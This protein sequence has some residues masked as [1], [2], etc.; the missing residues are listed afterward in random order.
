MRNIKDIQA[1]IFDMDG[2]I[3]DS[4]HLQVEAEKIVCENHHI[5][6]PDAEWSNFKGK[7][8]IDIFRYIIEKFS[9]EKLDPQQLADEKGQIY[10]K[11]APERLKL[12]PGAM[13]FIHKAKKYF[14]KL[15]V[16]TSS[17]PLTQ[18]LAFDIFDLHPHFSVLITGKD[19]VNGKPHPEPYLKAAEK[20]GLPPEVCMVIEDSDNGIRSAKAAGCV[21]VGV[22][23]SFPRQKL[24]EVGADYV[25]DS[26]SELAILLSIS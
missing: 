10:L 12:I 17:G 4:E 2:V 26:F 21:A 3:I 5:T 18:K 6:I 23:T 1:I 7:K 13:E 9:S 24:L 25:V 16:A 19:V 11:I 15:A 22:T 8:N 14:Q 20:L